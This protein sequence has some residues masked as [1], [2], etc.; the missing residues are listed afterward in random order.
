M[1]DQYKIFGAELSPYSVKIRSWFRYK[2]IPHVW[3]ARNSSNMEEY[4]RHAKLPIIPLVVSPSDTGIQDSTP[5]MDALDPE[6]PIPEVHP[7]DPVCNFMSLLLEEFSDEWGNKWMFHYRW[8][9]EADQLSAAT[10]I[11]RSMAPDVDEAQLNELVEQIRERMV[12]RVWFVGSNDIT[13]PIIE[14]SFVDSIDRLNSHLDGRSY[15]FGERPAYA[16]FALWGQL[17]N[18]WTDPT[19]GS[20]IESGQL[21]VLAWIHRMLW[22]MALGEFESWGTLRST[23]QPFIAEQVGNLFIP[24]TL[25]NEVAINE[26]HEEFSMTLSEGTWTQKPQKYH[27]KSLGMLRDKFT[28]FEHN[29][30]V[31]G[32]LEQT[33]CLKAFE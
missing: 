22:P 27:A 10:R 14:K 15:L 4:K 18:L 21:N 28:A 12:N 20:L 17:Y 16:D 3:T 30:A 33:D 29:Q 31:T 23:L 9:R 6:F 5:I 24:W 19:P 13:A 7:E 8:A 25:A 32:A 11:S 2:Q 1:A 26:G